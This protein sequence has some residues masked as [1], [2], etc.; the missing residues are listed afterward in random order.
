MRFDE[1]NAPSD[2]FFDGVRYGRMGGKR[3]YYLSQSSS[4]A[5]RKSPKGLHVAIWEKHN[6]EPVGEGNEINHIDGDT[7]NFSPEN[8]ERLPKDVHRRLPKINI[9]REVVRANLE[10]QRPLASAWHKS[11]TGRAW[12]I[13]VHWPATEQAMR[14]GWERMPKGENRPVLGLYACEWCGELFHRRDVRKVL[15]SAA[16]H[17]AKS[18]RACGKIKGLPVKRADK[19]GWCGEWLVGRDKKTKFCCV[20]CKS[21]KY[22]AEKAARLQSDG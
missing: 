17:S 11:D 9:D 5:G 18:K 13:G 19:C 6:G 7:F 15:C 2:V 22:R 12:H 14:A 20:P 16:C 10:K 21:A 3:K 8:L 4:N 1:D